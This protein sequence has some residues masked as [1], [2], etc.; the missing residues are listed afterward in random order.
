MMGEAFV[1]MKPEVREEGILKNT[2]D[3]MANLMP[4]RLRDTFTRS[5]SN[6]NR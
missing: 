1:S 2:I 6:P 4:P 3:M 5:N